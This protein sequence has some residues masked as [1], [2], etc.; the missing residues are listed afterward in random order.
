[1]GLGAVRED[2]DR[3]EYFID[4]ASEPNAYTRFTLWPRT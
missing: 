1:V 3:A 2:L 4:V